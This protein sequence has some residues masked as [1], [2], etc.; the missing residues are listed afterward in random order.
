MCFT[1]S[2]AGMVRHWFGSHE[3]GWRW[4]AVVNAIGGLLTLV[5]LIVVVSV[6]F[7]DGAWLV[8]VLIPVQVAVFEFIHRQYAAS[9]AHLALRPDHIVA[10][11][12][13]AERAVVPVSDLNR[14]VVQ[15]VN[16]A[17]AITD[18]VRAVLVAD[19]HDMADRVRERWE[20][21]VPGVPLVVVE[22]PFRALTGPL[23]AYLDVLDQAWPSGP[24]D[25]DHV[26]GHPRVRAA[27]LVG[28]HPVQPVHEPAS[29]GPAGTAEHGDH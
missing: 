6:K 3:T 22:S 4:R 23:V 29:A 5:V 11:P 7:R 16:V 17:R 25:A 15:A 8:V 27:P 21:Q 2:Q 9:K 13:R 14:A 20:R 26:R 12:H 10:P 1:L 28:T 18:D 24:G 19:D